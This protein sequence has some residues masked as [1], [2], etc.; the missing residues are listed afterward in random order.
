[1]PPPEPTP[2]PK[3]SEIWKVDLG[4]TTTRELKGPHYAVVLQSDKWSFLPCRLVMPI[5]SNLSRLKEGH[6]TLVRAAEVGLDHDSAALASQ[7]RAIDRK[8]FLSKLGEMADDALAPLL[9]T[10]FVFIEMP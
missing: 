8:R 10:L 3:R 1:M 4:A 7:V 6:G 2:N 5:T 9:E